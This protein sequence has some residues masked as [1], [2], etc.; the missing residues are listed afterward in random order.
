MKKAFIMLYLLLIAV[1]VQAQSDSHVTTASV[2][3][4]SDADSNSAPDGQASPAGFIELS[5]ISTDNPSIAIVAVL[6]VLIVLALSAL[7]LTKPK[8]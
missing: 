5:N 1:T 7:V 3:L 2:N 4:V 8:Q 6:L